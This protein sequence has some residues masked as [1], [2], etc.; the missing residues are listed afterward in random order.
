MI[1]DAGDDGAQLAAAAAGDVVV[2]DA[3]V[4][5]GQFRDL[6]GALDEPAAVAGEPL[7]LR[8]GDVA[9][10][11]AVGQPFQGGQA[12]MPVTR[13]QKSAPAAVTAQPSL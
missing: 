12:G 1:G 11:G 2:D 5:A 6:H 4:H 8:V 9:A 10:V 3:D 7:D 13:K